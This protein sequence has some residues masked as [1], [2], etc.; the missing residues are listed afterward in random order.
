MSATQQPSFP[1]PSVT[2]PFRVGDWLALPARHRLERGAESVQVGRRLMHLLVC[3]ASRPGAVVPR[4]ALLAA[5]WPG[6]MIAE[7]GLTVAISELRRIFQDDARSPQYI[8]TIRA[9]GYR[10][11]AP[12]QAEPSVPAGGSS[13]GSQ[14]ILRD[15]RLW[16][17]GIVA[18]AIGILGVRLL[19]GPEDASPPAALL[20]ERPLTSDPGS[21]VF[22]ALS[23]DGSRCAFCWNA[24][25]SD[26]LDLYVIQ[27]G[28]DRSLR[29]T[30]SPAQESDPV[31]SPG[32]DRIAF[33]RQGDEPGIYVTPA[34]GGTPRR[35]LPWDGPIRGL[36][37]SSRE[38][39][40]VFG[41][42][43]GD[44]RA[45]QLFLLRMGSPGPETHSLETPNVHHASYPRFSPDGRRV[46]FV[47]RD[48]AGL[49]NLFAVAVTGG[50]VE[51]LTRSQRSVLGLTWMP[52]G[53]SLIF[54]AAPA[55]GFQLWRLTLGN[56]RV[57]WMPTR[58]DR[59]AHP[60]ASREGHRLVFERASYDTDIWSLD[61]RD[62]V[63]AGA[64]YP[65]IA[66]THGDW[67]AQISPDGTAIAYVSDRSGHEE[68]WLCDRQGE[69][70][71]QLTEFG[72]PP[73]F[74]PCW[75]PEGRRI[76]FGSLLG[77][78]AA[79]WVCDAATREVACIRRADHH[80]LLNAWSPDGEWI[81]FSSERDDGW[82]LWRMG[83]DGI[84]ARCWRR[85]GR[86]FVRDACGEMGALY[87]H[88]ET[89]AVWMASAQ[90]QD[91]R[92]LLPDGACTQWIAMVAGKEGLYGVRADA[93]ANVLVHQPF[94][95]DA[96]RVLMALP[97][98]A[99]ERITLAPDDG[100]LLLD[101]FKT[102]GTDLLVVENC[103]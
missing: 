29:L 44:A 73:V 94:T 47:G 81:Y 93:E 35:L 69:G 87:L 64:T 88:R 32:G 83:P 21:E 40:L 31:W 16:L 103:R 61:L 24:G 60:T 10:L 51:Q 97:C 82:Q 37:W 63:P 74:H 22:P 77:D 12:V 90:E 78:R 59:V 4:D 38:E 48:R 80:E 7:E 26:N 100:N 57:T 39:L 33:V 46:V 95:G 41:G 62:D 66:S 91:D 18:A 20:Q 9:G 86:R 28:S 6:T 23:P 58:S 75:G 3:L 96:P 79:V 71:R 19:R 98:F 55:S 102:I 42:S 36:D 89:R 11:I 43:R 92:C 5:V 49:E 54:A 76:A 17:A 99:T 8:E 52:D 70:H 56:R 1:D 101:G 45:M 50:E 27:V 67:D 72:G 68:I 2:P 25:L 13:P 85:T 14:R 30:E 15:R 34:L 53:T 84:G 65:L